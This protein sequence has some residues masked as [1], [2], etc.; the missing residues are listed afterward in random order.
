MEFVPG[1]KAKENHALTYLTAEISLLGLEKE[2]QQEYVVLRGNQGQEVGVM[3]PAVSEKDE[4]LLGLRTGRGC[5]ALGFQVKSRTTETMQGP[6][7]LQVSF[8]PP[9]FDPLCSLRCGRLPMKADPTTP[10]KGLE[11]Q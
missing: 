5:P 11:M 1:A 7:I 9:G 10:R 8:P 3:R 4:A 2:R 6:S